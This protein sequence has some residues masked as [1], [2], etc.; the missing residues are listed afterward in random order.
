VGSGAHPA[1]DHGHGTHVAGIAA[2]TSNNAAGIAGLW[3]GP[4]LV[5]KVLDDQLQ[6]SS[7]TFKDGVLAAV[8]VARERNA[9]LVI[10]YSAGGNEA[11]T[12][13]DAVTYATENG[14][15]VVAAAGNANGGALIWPAAYS[16]QFPSVIA[17]GAV[18]RGDQR[19][20]FASRG[21]EM[22]LVAPGDAIVSALPDYQVTISR[23]DGQ[24]YGDLSGT[25]QAA[26]M[27]SALAA[28]LWA[29]SPELAAAEVRARIEEAC[30]PLGGA[31]E[32]FGRGIINIRKTLS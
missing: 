12:K 24:S 10:N 25:S 11:Q 8:R 2:A 27:V 32:D 3:P 22:T 30:D 23:R 21:P 28:L 1:D 14:A 31:A 17:V 13:R 4:V 20:S 29:K 7:V 9:R 16:S 19:P 15:L 6:G 18:D 5:V 26:P